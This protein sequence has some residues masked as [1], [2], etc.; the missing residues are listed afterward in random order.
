MST[1]DRELV[2]ELSELMLSL[3]IIWKIT[4]NHYNHNIISI[5]LEGYDVG[6]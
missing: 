2:Y 4:A 6:R 1:D 3:R 5:K